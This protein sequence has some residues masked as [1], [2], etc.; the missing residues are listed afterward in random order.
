MEILNTDAPWVT[1]GFHGPALILQVPRLLYAEVCSLG[2][3]YPSMDSYF[4]ISF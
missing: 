2:F 4:F 1:K 3:P